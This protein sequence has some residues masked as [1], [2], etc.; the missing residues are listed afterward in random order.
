MST[1]LEEPS[2]RCW[3]PLHQ[4]L[5]MNPANLEAAKLTILRAANIQD[6]DMMAVLAN[7]VVE[8]VTPLYWCVMMICNPLSFHSLY[9]HARIHLMN[10]SS[11]L[12]GLMQ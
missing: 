6:C 8:S 11:C 10:Q 3:P 1:N 4:A 7:Q 9:V 2:D 12:C 5:C